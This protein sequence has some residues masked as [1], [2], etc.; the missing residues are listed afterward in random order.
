[1]WFDGRPV[2]R[3]F[4]F[5]CGRRLGGSALQFPAKK[6]P[7]VQRLLFGPSHDKSADRQAALRTF[8]VLRGRYDD[9]VEFRDIVVEWQDI[10]QHEP[11]IRTLLQPKT[12]LMDVNI[13]TAL[14]FASRGGGRVGGGAGKMSPFETEDT[15]RPPRVLLLG[16]G[17]DEQMGGYGRH[18]KAYERGNNNNNNNELRLFVTGGLVFFV[19]VCIINFCRSNKG[20]KIWAINVLP[21]HTHMCAFPL[22]QPN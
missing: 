2:F 10:C 12:T 22:N 13:A 1:L 5:G 6:A 17:A 14:W 4:G 16:M 9:N 20:D 15:S 19:F 11:H 21:P 3:W 18:R 7:A 8:E